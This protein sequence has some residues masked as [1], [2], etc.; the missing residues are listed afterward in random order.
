LAGFVDRSV[1]MFLIG[2]DWHK[3]PPKSFLLI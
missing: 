2:F 1:V 3:N